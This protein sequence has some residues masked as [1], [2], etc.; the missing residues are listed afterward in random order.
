MYLVHLVGLT[1]VRCNV[2]D[3]RMWRKY[4]IAPVW[5]YG[6]EMDWLTGELEI[7]SGAPRVLRFSEGLVMLLPYY[8]THVLAF[9]M[10]R[11]L[12]ILLKST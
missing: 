1:N 5:L 6:T 10:Y 4:V 2:T 7:F 9:S 12:T 3:I 8:E 11:L